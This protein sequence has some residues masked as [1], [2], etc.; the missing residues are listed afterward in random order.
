VLLT[1][2]KQ[3]L[4]S[5]S[6]KEVSIEEILQRTVKNV[7]FSP[8]SPT[9]DQADEQKNPVDVHKGLTKV[10]TLTV[11]CERMTKETKS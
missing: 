9:E 3:D 5:A 7:E 10:L 4:D 6:T 1:A 8:P 11:Y 2:Q